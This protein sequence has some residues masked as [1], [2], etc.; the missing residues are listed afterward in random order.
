VIE[1]KNFHPEDAKILLDRMALSENWR[2][3][4]DDWKKQT[5][6]D[7][8]KKIDETFNFVTNKK[9]KAYP[10]YNFAIKN[11]LAKYVQSYKQENGKYPQGKDFEK[12]ITDT[13]SSI[14]NQNPNISKLIDIE[15]IIVG[16]KTGYSEEIFL[17]H[18][19]DKFGDSLS[20]KDKTELASALMQKKYNKA[21]YIVNPVVI[22]QK[23]IAMQKEQEQLKQ[24]QINRKINIAYQKAL[25]IEKT[26]KSTV[27]KEGIKKAKAKVEKAKTLEQENKAK[28][29]V[30][31]AAGNIAESMFEG[32]SGMLWKQIKGF[33]GGLFK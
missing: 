20:K 23:Q 3:L 1:L 15:N 14:N 19:D 4:N 6:Q 33:F 9:A 5:G 16:G 26:T 10:F 21:L 13:I 31:E 29:E 27:I 17:Q 28:Q 25:D 8:N 18:I 24:E 11:E 12:I 32:E 22:A 2:K 30:A 7:L